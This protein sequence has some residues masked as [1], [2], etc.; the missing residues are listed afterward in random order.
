MIRDHDALR[1]GTAWK[2]AHQL[3]LVLRLAAVAATRVDGEVLHVTFHDRGSFD[4]LLS[5]STLGFLSPTLP[6][7]LVKC[8]SHLF[9]LLEHGSWQLHLELLL[10]LFQF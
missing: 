4:T 1:R 5:M 9:L 7:R 3:F 10:D 2:R 8:L 6:L